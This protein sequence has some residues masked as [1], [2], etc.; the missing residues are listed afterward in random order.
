M[1][2]IMNPGLV[3]EQVFA[4]PEGPVTIGRTEES[5]I[6]VLH[7]SLSRRHA[8]LEQDGNRVFL[9]DLDSKNGT[10]VNEVRISRCELREGETF[11]CGEVRFRL[12][13]TARAL[14]LGL[15]PTQVQS[16]RTRF[17]PGSID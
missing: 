1:Q 9:V 5:T 12:V 13:S 6:C 11:R 16:L 4:L 14:P 2:L 10:F 17:S 3:D 8:R 15:A 7:K